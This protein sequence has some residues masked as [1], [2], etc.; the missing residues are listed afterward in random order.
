MREV[1][2]PVFCKHIGKGLNRTILAMTLISYTTAQHLAAL[3][4][5]SSSTKATETSP[6]VSST[7]PSA[8]CLSRSPQE[9]T[10]YELSTCCLY[11]CTTM[12]LC[13]LHE[14][15][16]L[17]WLLCTLQCFDDNESIIV[18]GYINGHAGSIRNICERW[19]VK[20]ALLHGRS[21]VFRY[22]EH[23]P[24]KKKKDEQLITYCNGGC[25]TRI[26]Y[27]LPRCK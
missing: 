25:E 3:S 27:T 5:E 2:S 9:A 18:G 6:P 1:T 16:S 14:E 24:Q 23:V 22:S 20:S 13:R 19:L 7:C 4:L 8:S 11:T 15:M 10:C 26:D 17:P 12:Q 21:W